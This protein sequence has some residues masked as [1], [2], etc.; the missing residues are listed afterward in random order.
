MQSIVYFTDTCYHNTLI[1]RASVT[2]IS[3]P[4][5]RVLSCSKTFAIPGKVEFF[6]SEGSDMSL[7]IPIVSLP[8]VD[9]SYPPQKKSFMMLKYM[10]DHY[11]DKYEWFMRADDDVYVK[12]DKLIAAGLLTLLC[13]PT[14]ILIPKAHVPN[15]PHI[16]CQ[17]Y[18]DPL[19]LS[20][21]Q[22]K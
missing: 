10:H 18:Y 6:S 20:P 15:Q 7:P 12:G 16:N 8:G 13:V 5:T 4:R 14:I 19:K 2:A 9:D 17:G 1:C 21:K 3:F 22:V 11:L